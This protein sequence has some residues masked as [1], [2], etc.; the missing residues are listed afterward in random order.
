MMAIKNTKSATQIKRQEVEHKR[1]DVPDVEYFGG[2]GIK[3]TFALHQMEYLFLK[4]E[5]K[6]NAKLER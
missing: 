1:A 3:D 5:K 6:V 4:A 2:D